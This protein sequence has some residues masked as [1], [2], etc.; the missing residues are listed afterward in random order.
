MMH[1]YFIPVYILAYFTGAR[2]MFWLLTRMDQPRLT[3]TVH[4]W[5]APLFLWPWRNPEP[6]RR[7]ES[8]ILRARGRRLLVCALT[9]S[10]LA[11]EPFPRDAAR[12]VVVTLRDPAEAARLKDAACQS[13]QLTEELLESDLLMMATPMWNFGIPSALKAWIDLVVR[14]GRTFQYSDRGVLGLAKDKK[15]ILVLASGGVFTEGP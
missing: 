14:P 7:L 4:T 8:V 11:E 13:D 1:L 3:E 6:E 2:G 9:L 10:P 15:A 5:R 12:E